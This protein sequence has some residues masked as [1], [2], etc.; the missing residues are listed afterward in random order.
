MTEL[1]N[2]KIA[3]ALS[4]V[5]E[6]DEGQNNIINTNSMMTAMD[7]YITKCIDGGQ[8]RGRAD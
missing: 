8:Q 5:A 6:I 4:S 3:A 2:S 1:Q 7:D